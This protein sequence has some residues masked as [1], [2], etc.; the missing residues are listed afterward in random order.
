M[1]SLRERIE[2]ESRS[3]RRIGPWGVPLLKRDEYS[4]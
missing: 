2:L 1:R 4:V 3:D